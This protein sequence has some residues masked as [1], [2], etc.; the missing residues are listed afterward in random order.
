VDADARA[1][2]EGA[3]LAGVDASLIESLWA[4]ALAIAF[5]QVC[6]GLG[7]VRACFV[8]TVVQAKMAG[9]EATWTLLAQKG[10]TWLKKTLLAKKIQGVDFLA[11]AAKVVFA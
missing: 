2:L 3:G 5:L 7:L 10:R 8:L 6:Q 1:G 9:D 11:E 4:T